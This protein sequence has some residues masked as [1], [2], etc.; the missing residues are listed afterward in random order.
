[1]FRACSN[2]AIKGI[3][4]SWLAMFFHASAGR[5]YLHFSRYAVITLPPT[6]STI[7]TLPSPKRYTG[8]HQYIKDTAI[9][10]QCQ[11]KTL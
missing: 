3:R 11:V 4:P 7:R 8:Y 1:M 9:K 5:T 6:Y 2:N 10:L